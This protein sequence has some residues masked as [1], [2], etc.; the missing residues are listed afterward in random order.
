LPNRNPVRL[1]L[2]YLTR[3]IQVAAYDKR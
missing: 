2:K 3:E 1:V